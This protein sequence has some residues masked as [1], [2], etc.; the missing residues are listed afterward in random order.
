VA[1]QKAY[2]EVLETTWTGPKQFSVQFNPAELTYSKAA[3]LAEIAIPGL[4]SPV[5]Q[6][7]RGTTETLTAELFF[8][9]TDQGMADGATSV[10]TMTDQFYQLVKQN[11]DTHAIPRCRFSWGAPAGG[12]PSDAEVSNA[13]SWF[14]CV[15]ESIERKF[16]LFSPE[17]VPLRAR[18]TVKM[19]EYKTVDQ[20]VKA[21]HSSDHTKAHILQKHERLDKISSDEYGTPAEWRLIADAN[22]LD[23]PRRIPPGTIL[24]I[25]P[26]VPASVTR[27]SS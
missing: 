24:Q 15:V 13:P 9:T 22:A 8:D 23:D 1:L 12:G 5:L 3:Q 18:L 26:M 27:S 16:V 17:G 19:R 14:T 20:M 21:L 2:F 10:T 6:F 4:D 25:P 7:V 11:A